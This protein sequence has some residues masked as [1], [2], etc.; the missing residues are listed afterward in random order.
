MVTNSIKTLKIVHVKKKNLK[1]KNRRAGRI[2]KMAGGVGVVAWDLGDDEG[3]E[4]RLAGIHSMAT[5][6]SQAM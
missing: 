5:R 3:V 4:V 6:G 1:K 2:R